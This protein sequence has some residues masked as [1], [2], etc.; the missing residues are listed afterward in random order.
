MES[1]ENVMAGLNLTLK[2]GNIGLVYRHTFSRMKSLP[3]GKW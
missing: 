1:E 3:A 2:T